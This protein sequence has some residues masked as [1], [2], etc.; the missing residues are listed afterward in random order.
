MKR[1]LHT[2][3]EKKDK[4]IPSQSHRASSLP[5]PLWRGGI[6]YGVFVCGHYT[7]GQDFSQFSYYLFLL[8]APQ[9]C[10]GVRCLVGVG[11]GLR[12]LVNDERCSIVAGVLGSLVV[13]I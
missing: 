10:F 9:L 6:L 2:V 12:F 3:N 8:T 13:S 5:P 1:R 7:D 11:K 4:K